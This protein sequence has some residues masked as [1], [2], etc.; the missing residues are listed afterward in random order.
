MVSRHS[1][2]NKYNGYTWEI[3]I[4]NLHRLFIYGSDVESFVIEFK[5]WK[6]FSFKT[7][8]S[9][10]SNDNIFEVV[11]ISF[12][13]IYNFFLQGGKVLWLYQSMENKK[14]QAISE[15]NSIIASDSCFCINKIR[16]DGLYICSDSSDNEN[17]KPN[18]YDIVLKFLENKCTFLNFSTPYFISKKDIDLINR[19]LTINSKPNVHVSEFKCIDYN[20]SMFFCDDNIEETGIEFVGVIKSD[21]LI[22]DM[23]Y[24]DYDYSTKGLKKTIQYSK[25]IFNFVSYNELETKSNSLILGIDDFVGRWQDEDSFF[26]LSKINL[27]E[28]N[29]STLLMMAHSQDGRHVVGYATFKDRCMK[30]HYYQSTKDNITQKINNTTEL[31]ILSYSK[32]GFRYKIVGEETEFYAKKERE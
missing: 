10:V 31:Q 6:L 3:E 21:F 32:G 12:D 23:I 11:S 13:R 15:I 18:S 9:F 7:H 2:I 4:N 28:L 19:S 5:E 14:I 8:F 30:I 26:S 24:C 20:V 22:L 29:S 1:N 27:P 16:E 17:S 25:L